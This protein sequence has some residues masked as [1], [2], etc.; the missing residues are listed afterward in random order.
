M[1]IPVDG[2]ALHTWPE[3]SAAGL[4]GGWNL[5]HN[6]LWIAATAIS[7]GVPLASCDGDHLRIDDDRLDLIFLPV[8]PS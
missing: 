8:E 4:R 1:S 7:V 5:S 3:L 2:E 6:D